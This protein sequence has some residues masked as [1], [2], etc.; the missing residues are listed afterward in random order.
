MYLTSVATGRSMNEIAEG[1]KSSSRRRPGPQDQKAPD[2]PRSPG[3]RRGDGKFPKFRP[4]QKATLVDHVPAGSGWLFEMKYDGYRCL[5]AIADGKAKVYTRTGLDWTD[6]FP[7]IAAAAAELNVGSALLDGEIVSVDDKGN[8]NFSAL[9]QAISEAAKASACSCSTR[10]RSTARTWRN[11]PMSSA[12]RGSPRRWDRCAA[13][14]FL[15]RPCRRQG[16]AIVRGDVRGWQEGVIAK[17]ADSLYR[18]DRTK[19]WL[20]IKCTNRQELVIVG[21]TPSDKKGRG[22]RSLLLALHEESGKLRYA[23]K[24]GTGFSQAVQIELRE[25]LDA[26]AVEKAPVTVP[27]PEAR[28]ARWVKPDLVAEIAFAEFTAD[29]VVRHASFLGLRGDKPAAQVVKETPVAAPAEAAD[30][31]RISNPDRVIFPESKI[32]K[33]ELAAYYRAVSPLMLEWLASRPTS[34]VRCPQGRARKCFFQKHDSGSFG[35]HVHHVPVREK[36]AARDFSTSRTRP[37]CTCVQMGTIEFHGWGSRVADIEKPDRLV[38]D[39]D[40][41]EGLDF[42]KVKKAAVRVRDLVDQ[43]GL[44]SFPLLTG[45]KGIHVVIPLDQTADWPE[46]KSFADRFR[47]LSPSGPEASPP[48][49]QCE[50]PGQYRHRLLRQPR[51]RPAVLPYSSRSRTRRRS[52]RRSTGLAET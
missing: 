12:R 43:L 35:A 34:L 39:L 48:A 31:V 14:H 21:W 6:K 13:L 24:V 15:C 18:G 40:P 16:R 19:A 38:F 22:F 20:K 47:A 26:L 7:E 52:L 1:V 17:K 33:G 11:A 4:L 30:Q 2:S 27:R 3:L 9:Q 50:A 44:K 37:E 5:L 32:T 10:W 41:D 51:A 28:G 42:D 36:K 25:K 49:L 8:T 46:V 45:G 23:G 29:N